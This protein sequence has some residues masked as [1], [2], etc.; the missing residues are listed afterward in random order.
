MGVAVQVISWKGRWGTGRWVEIW[1]LIIVKWV[2]RGPFLVLHLMRDD[3]VYKRL[4]DHARTIV[5]LTRGRSCRGSGA[6]GDA[7]GQRMIEKPETREADAAEPDGPALRR[8]RLVTAPSWVTVALCSRAGF[9]DLRYERSRAVGATH[10]ERDSKQDERECG[11][12]PRAKEA[13]SGAPT[14]KRSHKE[15]L[16]MAETRLDVF[17]VSLEELYQGKRKLLG[18]ESSQEEA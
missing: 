13:Q 9:P 2:R 14:E 17:E 12:S 11:Y 15:R 18:V 8:S 10:E 3:A 5:L 1:E 4:D 16:T 6:S 7:R